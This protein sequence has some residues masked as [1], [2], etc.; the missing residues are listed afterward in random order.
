MGPGLPGR[1][2]CMDVPGAGSP[3][4]TAPGSVSSTLMAPPCLSTT[5]LTMAN[6]KPE[7]GIP[8]AGVAR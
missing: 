4:I 7:P 5:C 8:R 1:S 2:T 6:P 3:S